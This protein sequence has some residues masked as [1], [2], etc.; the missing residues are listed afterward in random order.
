MRLII[1][2]LIILIASQLNGSSATPARDALAKELRNQRRIGEQS[3]N[4][5]SLLEQK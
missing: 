5:L 3:G 1:S 2:L 4:Y